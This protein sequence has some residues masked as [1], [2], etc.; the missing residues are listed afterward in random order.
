MNKVDQML[1]NLY[2]MVISGWSDF[3][4]D[5]QQSERG[6]TNFISV[7]L[8]LAIVLILAGFFLTVVRDMVMPTV[9]QKVNDFMQN[10]G[11]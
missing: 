4:Q 10:L 5:F 1:I 7:L 9:Q 2:V 3:K 11:G 8:I 6:D